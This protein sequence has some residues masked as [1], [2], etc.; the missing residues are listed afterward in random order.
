[1]QRERKGNAKTRKR[2]ARLKIETLKTSGLLELTQE[3]LKG[4]SVRDAVLERL[5]TSGRTS[6]A[7][8]TPRNDVFEFEEKISLDDYDSGSRSV[9]EADATPEESQAKRLCSRSQVERE[10][11]DLRNRLEQSRTFRRETGLMNF[12]TDRLGPPVCMGSGSRVGNSHRPSPDDGAEQYRRRDSR[13]P[14]HGRSRGGK[15]HS[16]GRTGGARDRSRSRKRRPNNKP[17]QDVSP[18]AERGRKRARSAERGGGDQAKASAVSRGR[19]LEPMRIMHMQNIMD[20]PIPEEMANLAPLTAVA[21]GKAAET[22]VLQASSTESTPEASDEATAPAAASF[23]IPK[24][25]KTQ[26]TANAHPSEKTHREESPQ[27]KGSPGG[28]EAMVVDLDLDVSDKDRRFVESSAPDSIVKMLD[29]FIGDKK[30]PVQSTLK[31]SLKRPEDTVKKPTG[32][33]VKKLSFVDDPPKSALSLM[34][35]SLKKASKPSKTGSKNDEAEMRQ[36]V[37]TLSSAQRAAFRKMLTS[38]LP[39]PKKAAKKSRK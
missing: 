31:P 18:R 11:Q 23:K 4:K 33:A 35:A 24:L 8:C 21:A 34:A 7:D 12:H 5:N 10:A 13:S 22:P 17:R 2:G 28:G 1:V 36:L 19:A 39:S 30:L 32:T 15:T 27:R 16:P 9:L 20:A 14:A 26:P 38:T 25:S 29:D 37:K 6:A 3:A